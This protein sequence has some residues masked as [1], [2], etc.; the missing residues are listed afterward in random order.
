MSNKKVGRPKIELD[1]EQIIKLATFH[2]TL[3]EMSDFFGV[4]V[5]TLRDNYST[6]I[7][8]GKSEGKIRLR[9]KQFEVAVNG[10]GNPTMLI[11]LGK[12]MLGQVDGES[13]D[14][15]SPLPLTDIL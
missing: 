5:D 4:S 1:K 6:E 3:Q 7:A 10:N 14:D 13:G 11:W 12:Q 9:K 8:K 15:A 2:C